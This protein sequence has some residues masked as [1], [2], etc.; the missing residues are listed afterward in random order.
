MCRV[1]REQH[2]RKDKKK[3]QGQGAGHK[4]PKQLGVGHMQQ[5]PASSDTLHVVC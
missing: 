4:P 5:P 1:Q 3:T 2:Q